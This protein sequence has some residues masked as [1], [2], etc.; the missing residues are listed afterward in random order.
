MQK[1]KPHNLRTSQNAVMLS[2]V[3]RMRW[4]WS[5]ARIK[6]MRNTYTILVQ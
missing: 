6:Q 5:V 3:R 2:K 1:E 4:A